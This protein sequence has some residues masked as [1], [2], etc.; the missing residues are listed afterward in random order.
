MSN[1]AL[2]N[3]RNLN[4]AALVNGKVHSIP[5]WT[6][7]LPVLF[8]FIYLNFT[9]FL[10]AFGPLPWPVINT[11]KLYAF[12]FFAHISLLLGY[13]SVINRHSGHYIGKWNTKR[14]IIV[15][16]V[17][18]LLLLIPTSISRSGSPI[19]NVAAG[20]YE[21]GWTYYTARGLRDDTGSNPVEYVRIVFGPV[22]FPLLP[23]TIYYWQRLAIS[24]RLLSILSIIGFVFIYIATGTNKAVADFILICPWLIVASIFAGIMKIRKIHLTLFLIIGVVLVVLFANFFV[25]GQKNRPG[26]NV[27]YFS[28]INM[29]ADLDNF[30]VRDLSSN[31][32]IGVVALTG[33]LTQGYYA[34]SLSLERPFMPMF[35]VGNSMFLYR[36]AARI[37]GVYA[38]EEMPYPVQIEKDGWDAYGRWSSIYPWIASDVSFPGVIVIVFLIGRLFALSW[39]D[40]LTGNNPFAIIMFTQFITMLYYFPANNQALQS[41]E[42]L[43]SFY[44]LLILW[45]YTRNSKSGV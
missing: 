17:V 30:M 23:L 26:A 37:T 45:L 24:I 3:E 43:S 35:G 8:F 42:S 11:V 38:I 29:N 34:L 20:F 9:V 1:Y 41:G 10:F 15:S 28:G 22:L 13:I 39:L 44:V 5:L 21:P 40:S 6:R 25:E 7:L 27:A 4:Y 19:P 31:A 12:L 2:R 36:N 16:L 32:K 18:N 33:Y 14:I